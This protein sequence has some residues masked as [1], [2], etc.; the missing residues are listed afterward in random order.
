MKMNVK[1][2]MA[3]VITTVTITSAA[4]TALVVSDTNFSLMA[5]HAIVSKYISSRFTF[6]ITLG[7]L[8][9]AE[10]LFCFVCFDITCN[11]VSNDL[12][13]LGRTDWTAF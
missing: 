6:K 9:F 13:F 4:I 3:A 2:R 8:F 11:N 12:E 7:L 5:S 10:V 1:A